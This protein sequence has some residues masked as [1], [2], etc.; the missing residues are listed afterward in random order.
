MEEGKGKTR[1]RLGYTGM[2]TKIYIFKC[3]IGYDNFM[4]RHAESFC[5]VSDEADCQRLGS[6]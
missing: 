2:L 5:L 6:Q 4:Y 3:Y 1:T